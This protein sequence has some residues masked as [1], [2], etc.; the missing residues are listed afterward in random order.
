VLKESPFSV[1]LEKNTA[2]KLF[3][4]QDE[5]DPTHAKT[6]QSPP[7]KTFDPQFT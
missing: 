6:V 1:P 7:V 2:L 4:L 5:E 3:G